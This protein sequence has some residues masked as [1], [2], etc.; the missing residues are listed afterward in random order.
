MRNSSNEETYEDEETADEQSSSETAPVAQHA[1]SG[2]TIPDSGFVYLYVDDEVDVHASEE[3][4]GDR[5]ENQTDKED[6][7]GEQYC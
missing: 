5:L 7:H 6:L 1:I 3:D 4:K 2:V